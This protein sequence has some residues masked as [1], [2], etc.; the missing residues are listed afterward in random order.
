M[1]KLI[2]LWIVI[3]ALMLI[4]G[5]LMVSPVAA[6]ETYTATPVADTYV[7][8][9]SPDDNYGVASSA[10][11]RSSPGYQMIM[12]ILPGIPAPTSTQVISAELNFYA[13]NNPL[14]IDYS[15][16][17][18]GWDET[19]TTWNNRPSQIG[20]TGSITTSNGWNK[21]DISGIVRN[22]QSVQMVTPGGSGY[23]SYVRPKEHAFAPFVKYRLA[24]TPEI[25][26]PEPQLIHCYDFDTSGADFIGSNDWTIPIGYGSAVGLVNNGIELNSSGSMSLELLFDAYT[27]AFFAQGDLSVYGSNLVLDTSSD[28]DWRHYAVVVS[29][30]EIVTY[31]NGVADNIIYTSPPTQTQ[32]ASSNSSI[33]DQFSVYTG[34]AD[35]AALY[36]AGPLACVDQLDPTAV[37]IG[38][39]LVDL[40]SGK[41]AA[42]D[43]TATAGEAFI[44]IGLLV[45]TFILL[46]REL[47]SW[48]RLNA[49]R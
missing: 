12:Y 1:N 15:A 49:K 44:A 24:P 11:I 16:A 2:W 27:Y 23:L 41:L 26:E 48:A 43:Y 45:I 8:E 21:I 32:I 4:S 17:L 28:N 30:D 36:A 25:P 10:L 7:R 37:T 20:Y 39:T 14:P 46:F 18:S 6:Q 38:R 42:V 40:P 13:Y 19:S 35:P 34:E 3:G 22:G 47:V 31:V 9:Q 33:I 5:L 29:N